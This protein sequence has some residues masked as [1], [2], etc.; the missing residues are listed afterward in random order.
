MK[1]VFF[2]VLALAFACLAAGTVAFFKVKEK[3]KRL[4]VVCCTL[5][6]MA[7]WL[8]FALCLGFFMR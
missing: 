2:I 3:S 8:A 5:G 4:V 7:L 1:A 6:A